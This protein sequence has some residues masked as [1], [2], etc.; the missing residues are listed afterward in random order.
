VRER[1]RE[2]EG[3]RGQMGKLLK[4]VF[5][6]VNSSTK[7]FLCHKIEKRILVTHNLFS[8]IFAIKHA[9]RH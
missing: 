4:N 9:Q 1:E 6:L 3:E 8:Q 7:Y 2:R 5:S